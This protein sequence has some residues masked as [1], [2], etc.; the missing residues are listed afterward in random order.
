MPAYE[1]GFIDK[2]WVNV[3]VTADTEKDAIEKA[4]KKL[5]GGYKN[6]D[7]DIIDDK[8]TYVGITNVDVLDEMGD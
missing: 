3:R 5:N 2:N 6:K 7:I 4:Q 8:T 1:V